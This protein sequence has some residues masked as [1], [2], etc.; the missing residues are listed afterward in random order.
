MV[1]LSRAHFSLVTLDVRAFIWWMFVILNVFGVIGNPKAASNEY[2]VEV[3]VKVEEHPI[4]L[5]S[6]CME[7]LFIL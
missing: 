4:N 3:W 2:S 7:V 5:L 1:S 6:T